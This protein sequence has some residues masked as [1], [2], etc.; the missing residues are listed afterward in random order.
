M[1]V[2]G[3]PVR[4]FADAGNVIHKMVS[5]AAGSLMRWTI[6]KGGLCFIKHRHGDFDWCSV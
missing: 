3:R 5:L 6:S 2:A 4:A 1:G